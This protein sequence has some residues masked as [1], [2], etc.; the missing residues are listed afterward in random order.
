M[1]NVRSSIEI[2]KDEPTRYV[3]DPV[4]VQVGGRVR[5][6]RVALKMSK[7]E[8]GMALG[9]TGSTLHELESGVTRIG[10]ERLFEISKLLKCPAAAFFEDIRICAE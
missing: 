2:P 7:E 9:V 6:R 3:R 1:P 8:L 5:L 4:D 10:A